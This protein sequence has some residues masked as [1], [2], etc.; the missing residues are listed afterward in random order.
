MAAVTHLFST[1]LLPLR[2]AL[3]LGIDMFAWTVALLLATVVRLELAD[4]AVDIGRVVPLL[5]VM[6]VSHSVAGLFLVPNFARYRIGSVGDAEASTVTV[7]IATVPI[8]LANVFLPTQPVPFAALALA[9]PTALLSMFA[10]RLLWRRF[11]DKSLRENSTSQRRVLVFGA[12]EGGEQII[13]AMKNDPTSEFEPVGILDDSSTKQGRVIHGVMVLGRR[14]DIER[15]AKSTDASVLLLAIPSATSALIGELDDLSEACGL[16]LLVLPTTSELI[17][18]LRVSD[19]RPFT[20]RDLLGRAEVEVDLEAIAQVVTGKHVLV[21]G[22]G[23]SIGSELCRQL[24]NLAP[25]RLIMLDRDESALHAVQLSIEGKALLDTPDLVVADIRDRERID[26]IFQ[27]NRPEV[28]FHTAALKHLT[29]LEQHPTE[30]VKTNVEGTRNLLDAAERS[31]VE[32]FVNVSTDKAADPT[33]V[34]GRT[35]QMAERLTATTAARA[36]GTFVSVRFGNVLGS[37]GSVLPTFLNQIERGGPLTVTDPDVTRYFM[38]IPE[39]VRLVLQASA[40]GAPGEIM[41]LDMGEPVK[42]LDMARRLIRHS[43]KRIEIVFTGLRPGE[44]MH[45][46]LIAMNELGVVREHARIFH[47]I[48]QLVGEDPAADRWLVST[49]ETTSAS[50][51]G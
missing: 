38:T 15:V 29:L 37:R 6:A 8:V 5:V 48:G 18:N 46:A 7:A 12:G 35:K 1:K 14:R 22:A 13:R 3:L 31:G 34:L 24:F 42:I 43:G 40:I 49:E 20:E 33:S 2:T 10:I 36:D 47:T 11:R 51:H 25:A 30:G 27:M 50:Q 4:S 9:I 39:A 44:K 26:E 19:I 41:I 21:T 45:E 23:G 16:D 32:R 28:V 17:N